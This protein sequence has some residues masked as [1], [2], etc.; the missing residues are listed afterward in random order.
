[1][2]P[3][4]LRARVEAAI[5]AEIEPVL[6]DRGINLEQAEQESLRIYFNAYKG[7]KPKV[8]DAPDDDNGVA[9]YYG[10]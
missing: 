10:A 8:P 3:N 6:W 7:H 4:D 9:G 5:E 1:M 2:D